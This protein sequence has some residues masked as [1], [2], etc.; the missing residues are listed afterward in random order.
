M[1]ADAANTGFEYL[2]EP[3]GNQLEKNAP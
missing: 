2:N 1:L 3:A